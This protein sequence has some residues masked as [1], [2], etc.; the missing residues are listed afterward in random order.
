M[1]KRPEPGSTKTRLSPLLTPALAAQLYECFLED[2]IALVAGVPNWD[3]FVAYTPINSA[4]YFKRIAPNL[5]R[6]PQVGEGLGQRLVSVF[7]ETLAKGYRSVS[8][9][10]SDGP[11]LPQDYLK[12]ALA[13]IDQGDTDL[14][15][16]P[17][18]DGGY[19]LV[20]GKKMHPELFLDVEMS[21]PTV[22]ADTL[23]IARR[24]Q[25]K[26][27]LLPEWYDVDTPDDLDRLQQEL[28]NNPA[29]APFTRAFLDQ[30]K[31]LWEPQSLFQR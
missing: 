28:Q 7:R 9:I 5:G 17:S 18:Q 24:L 10:N 11:T 6:I 15:F 23:A 27:Q 13:E 21:T 26:V 25:L 19:Y 22:L 12:R 3:A 31:S 16:G 1:A 8:A 30:P 14:V 2:T 29:K 4:P 20:A